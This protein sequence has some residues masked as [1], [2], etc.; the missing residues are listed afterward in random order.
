MSTNW[1]E[2]PVQFSSVH[3]QA[4]GIS[5]LRYGCFWTFLTSLKYWGSATEYWSIK[6]D[7][8]EASCFHFNCVRRSY[9][10]WQFAQGVG[11]PVVHMSL[12]QVFYFVTVTCCFVKDHNFWQGGKK[13]RLIFPRVN[14]N[15]FL[16]GGYGMISLN[17]VTESLLKLQIWSTGLTLRWRLHKTIKNIKLQ[18]TL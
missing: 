7:C 14:H 1:T 13:R 8:R 9:N 17:D 3:W 4:L 12:Q 5:L 11:F 6:R 10:V 18:T 2:L 16:C 15:N